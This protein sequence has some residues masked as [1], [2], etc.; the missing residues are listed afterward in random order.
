MRA[1]SKTRG[2]L[3]FSNSIEVEKGSLLELIK[4]AQDRGGY[5]VRLYNRDCG[6][7]CLF[8]GVW[9]L[10]G[11]EQDH[12]KSP[13]FPLM[14]LQSDWEM[15]VHAAQKK[16]ENPANPAQELSAALWN[17]LSDPTDNTEKALMRIATKYKCEYTIR[18]LFVKEQ[19]PSMERLARKGG[20]A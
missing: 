10:N 16:I 7:V 13:Q 17:H 15:Q 6:E 2:P 8:H 14:W 12:F 3:S 19:E 18:K 1:S 20:N 9:Y 11:E 5:E 4:K